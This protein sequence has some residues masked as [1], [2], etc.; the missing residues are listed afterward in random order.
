MSA[1]WGATDAGY[2]PLFDRLIDED[3]RRRHEPRPHRTH[4]RAGVVDSI[5]RELLRLF[6][7]RAT[8]TG[9]VAFS[10][11]RT[12]LDYGLPDLDWGGRGVV[13]EQRLRL[14]R[15]LRDTIT[16]FEPRLANVNVEVRETGERSGALSAVVDGQLLT[17]GVREPISFMLPLGSRDDSG[18]DGG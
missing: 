13:P 18:G 17:E 6:S 2:V 8:V 15:L 3:L 10:R 14:A 4:D 1:E 11:P 9:D 16:A 7:T 5:G 12:C